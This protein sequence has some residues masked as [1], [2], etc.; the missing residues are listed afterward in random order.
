MSFIIYPGNDNF[1][2][3]SEKFFVIIYA[4]FIHV[5][6]LKSVYFKR[7][8]TQKTIS[9]GVY[10]KI[11][12][13][14]SSIRKPLPVAVQKFK[15][16]GATG[17]QLF[18]TPEYLAYTPE[19]L[20]EIVRLCGDN[21]LEITA[22][23]GDMGSCR[24]GVTQE[25][26]DRAELLKRIID[27]ACAFGSRIVT[28]H[29]GVVPDDSRDPVFENMVRSIGAC[30][31]YAASCGAYFAI[32][33]GPESAETLLRL[34]QAVDSRGLK[35]NLDPANL[36]MVSCVDPV[37]AVEVLG[38]YIIHTHAKDGINHTPGSTYAR[39]GRYN[40]DGEWQAVAEKA[41]TFAEVPLG[42]GQVPWDAYLNAL[43]KI[44]YDGYLVVE[45]EQGT[46][47]EEDI[48]HG[49]RFLKEKLGL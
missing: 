34:L 14:S 7:R 37:H 6:F 42:T 18:A 49:V 41:P 46:S 40:A 47:R 2:R 35:V 23:C 31:E 13:L 36:R 28:T 32:E 16:M 33:T 29:I 45:R 5:I 8:V 27:I 19:R 38:S 3:K 15:E 48:R 9:E 26:N 22:V 24:F 20:K 12:A 44:G 30:A 11:G 1:S 25:M 21:G 10:M 4:V 43:K 17:I 39:Y